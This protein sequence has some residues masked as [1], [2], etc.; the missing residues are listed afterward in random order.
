[1]AKYL[2]DST[3]LIYYLRGRTGVVALVASLAEDGHE[4]GVCAVNV[5]ELYSRL[6]RRDSP[7]AE[8]L[9]HNLV[10]YS[11]SWAD[12]KQAG[13]YRYEFA[14]QGKTLTVADTL[15]AA[16]AV[17]QGCTLVTANRKDYPMREIKLLDQP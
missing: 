5:A 16:V 6:E 12:A 2:L 13:R 3:V 17:A 9:V 1:M 7:R 14:H 10:Y 4:L 11:I 8:A 15:I